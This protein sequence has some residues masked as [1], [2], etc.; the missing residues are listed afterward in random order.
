MWHAGLLL[1]LS[2]HSANATPTSAAQQ[3]LEPT[4]RLMKSGDAPRLS[5][6]R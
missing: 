2:S 5:C 1:Y 6:R 4:A 3:Q